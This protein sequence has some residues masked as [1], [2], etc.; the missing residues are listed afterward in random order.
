M[1]KRTTHNV[2]YKYFIWADIL[3]TVPVIWG[4]KRKIFQRIYG[5]ISAFATHNFAVFKSL[6]LPRH[7]KQI[8]GLFIVT[9]PLKVW[10]KYFMI[11]SLYANEEL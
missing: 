2:R 10:I 3:N 5:L 8:Q 11:P 9:T 1:Q 7:H 6:H 4:L